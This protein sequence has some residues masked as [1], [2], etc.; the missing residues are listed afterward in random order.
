[1]K[2][3]VT[4]QGVATEFYSFKM[5]ATP[6]IPPSKGNTPLAPLKGGRK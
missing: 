2:K 1:M 3:Y 6:P 4:V 5:K